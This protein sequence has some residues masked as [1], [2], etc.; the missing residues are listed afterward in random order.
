MEINAG[1]VVISDNKILLMHPKGKENKHEWSIP[2]GTI[3]N[4]EGVMETA[5]RETYEETGV[6]INPNDIESDMHIFYYRKKNKDVIKYIYYYI[7]NIRPE[8][9]K[10]NNSVIPNK[11]VDK[12][13]FFTK[14]EAEEKLKIKQTIVLKYLV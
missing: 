5:I 2:K 7:V 4:G 1:L 11:E 6:I 8:D 9:V 12:F 13:G 14:E 3:E 10:I